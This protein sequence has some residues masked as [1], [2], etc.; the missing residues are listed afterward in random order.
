MD[1][2]LSLGVWFTY[3][4]QSLAKN[5]VLC[6]HVFASSAVCLAVSC[7]VGHPWANGSADLR[8]GEVRWTSRNTRCLS[9]QWKKWH[10]SV[11]SFSWAFMSLCVPKHEKGLNKLRVVLHFT[12]VTLYWVA[13]MNQEYFSDYMLIWGKNQTPVLT[14]CRCL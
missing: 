14:V 9:H 6:Q 5:Q 4:L 13:G 11:L 1:H 10:P 12:L 8:Q 3:E 2:L 7:F